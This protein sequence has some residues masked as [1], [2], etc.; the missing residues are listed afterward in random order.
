MVRMLEDYNWF[1]FA[2]AF[3]LLGI[4]P[5]WVIRIFPSGFFTKVLITLV[6]GAITFIAVKTGGTKRGI[7]FK[8]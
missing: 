1:G 3:C 6:L 5:V 8:K 4:I 2:I 7:L